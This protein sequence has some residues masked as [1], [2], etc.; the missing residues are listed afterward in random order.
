MR[1]IKMKA[2]IFPGV[3]IIVEAGKIVRIDLYLIPENSPIKVEPPPPDYTNPPAA[4][5]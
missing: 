1:D 5:K 3:V 4:D 2:G